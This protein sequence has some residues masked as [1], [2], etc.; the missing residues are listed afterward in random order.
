MK[1]ENKLKRRL[2]GSFC[3]LIPLFGLA[4]QYTIGW[5]KIG[6]GGG[7]STGGSY[8]VSGTIGQA[9]AS[10]ALSGGQYSVVGGFWSLVPELPTPGAPAL[11]VTFVGNQVMVSWPASAR[12]WTLQT[13]SN[14]ATPTWGDYSGP[15]NTNSVTISPSGNLFFRLRQ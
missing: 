9:D 1:T 5:Y 14:L 8:Q 10:T 2:L 7:A 6:G 3:Y 13:N 15:V 4:D 11:T 12:G